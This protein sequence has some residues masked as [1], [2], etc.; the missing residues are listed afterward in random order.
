MFAS[1]ED[2]K[3]CIYTRLSKDDGDKPESDS[4]GNQKALIRDFVKN[5]PEIQVVSTYYSDQMEEMQ[6]TVAEEIKA[7]TYQRGEEAEDP[8]EVTAEEITE[9]DIMDYLFAKYPDLTGC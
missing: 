1:K 7:G 8:Q 3:A 9:E 5:H 4:I 6:E 2:Y